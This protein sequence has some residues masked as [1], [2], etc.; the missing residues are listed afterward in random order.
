[1]KY[2]QCLNVK[3]NALVMIYST[4]EGWGLLVKTLH[5]FSPS[6][7]VGLFYAEGILVRKHV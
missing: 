1:M 2:V 3:S 5:G 4:D 7:D 6:L